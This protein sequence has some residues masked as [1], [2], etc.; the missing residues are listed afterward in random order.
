MGLSDRRVQ[1]IDTETADAHFDEVA[2][3]WSV[4]RKIVYRVTTSSGYTIDATV[5]HPLLVEGEWRELGDVRSGDLLAV[6][7]REATS[8]DEGIS[9]AEVSLAW[10]AVVSIEEIGE[11]ECFD[12]Q[13]VNPERP[14]AL[15]GDVLVHN[16]GKKI[17]ELIAKERVKFVDGCEA[18]GYGRD[19]GEQW[20]DIIEPFADYAFNKSHSYGYGLVSYQTAWLKANY[21][22]EYYSALLTSVKSSLEKAAVYL[23][24][25]RLHDIRV[26]V[27]DIN[28]SMSDFEPVVGPEASGKGEV[29]FGLSAVRN[30]GEGLVE[31]IVREREANGP[32]DDF[33]DFANRVEPQVLNKR[34][35]ESLIKAGAFE[36]MGHPRK[37][38][39]EVYAPIVDRVVARRRKEAEGQF[40]LFAELEADT[41]GAVD[42]SRLPIPNVEF[43]KKER[44]VNE[45]EMLGL[46]VS[47]HP[48]MGV[49]GALRRRVDASIGELE[50]VE[51]G[52]ILRVGGLVTNLRRK[53]TKKG[54]LM[55][56]FALED[57]AA[58]AE[59]VVFPK[60][61]AAVGHVLEDDAVVVLKVRVDN[62]GE[63]LK[64]VAMEV[65]KLDVE[66]L[67]N[68]TLRVKVPAN[69][70]DPE[71]LRDIRELL[72]RYPGR[73]PVYLHIG[74]R[75]L[76]LPDDFAVEYSSGLLAELRIMLGNGCILP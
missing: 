14:Y 76:K 36:S 60:T 71:S 65:E 4:G 46:Y 58:S 39:L 63:Q 24:E 23:N 3:V 38:L 15:V 27:P 29:L 22:V 11:E 49:D 1:T 25:C 10:D 13:M 74:D 5:E 18:N 57:L 16:C 9:D 21:P 47:E 41:P 45:R 6:A 34:T 37:G 30:V 44:L 55:A 2:D 33:Y 75:T 17:R 42:D 59:V 28:R 68:A 66:R 20:F 67:E 50:D 35:L 7:S 40:E 73:S 8:V 43:E 62:S 64:L 52:T 48:L 32:F 72:G 61:M 12:F 70:T 54:D 51:T 19:L 26:L 53:W 69:R 31:Q 56:I